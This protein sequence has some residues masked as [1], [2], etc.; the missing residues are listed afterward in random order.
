[1]SCVVAFVLY[2]NV[3]QSSATCDVVLYRNTVL[4]NVLSYLRIP[5]PE[6]MYDTGHGSVSAAWDSGAG[7]GSIGFEALNYL[8]FVSSTSFR[9]CALQQQR[10]S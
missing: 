7:T 10:R 5:G 6:A 1:M 8:H 2:C 3:S 4:Y 9:R